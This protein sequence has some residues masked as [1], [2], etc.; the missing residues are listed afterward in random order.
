[1]Q[2]QMLRLLFLGALLSSVTVTS[3]YSQQG[4]A[5]KGKALFNANCAACHQLDKKM[6][7]PALRYVEKRLYEDEGLDRAWL[8]DWIR[9]SSS[10]IKSG[11]V[12]ANKIYNEYNGAAMTAYPQFSDEDISN[13]LAYTAQDKTVPA[14]AAVAAVS[15]QSSAQDSDFSKIPHSVGQQPSIFHDDD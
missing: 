12:Y 6:T 15:S 14:V 10:L 1:M 8:N 7:G 3:L 11:D 13:I 2:N 4:D 9:N 5:T